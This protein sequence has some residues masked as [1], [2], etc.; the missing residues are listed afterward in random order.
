MLNSTSKTHKKQSTPAKEPRTSDR[1]KNST[2]QQLGAISLEAYAEANCLDPR[3]LQNLGIT[4]K[5][6]SG[7]PALRIPYYNQNKTETATRYQFGLDGASRFSW[8]KESRI[9]PYGLWKLPELLQCCTVDGGESP[10]LFLVEGESNA[11]TMWSHGIPALGIPGINMWKPEWTQYL[12]GLKVYIWREPGVRG[13]QFVARIGHDLPDAFI[14]MPPVGREDINECHML[15]DDVPELSVRLRSEAVP[16]KSIADDTAKADAHEAYRSAEELLRSNILSEFEVLVHELG[17]VGEIENAKLLYLSVTSRLLEKPV[18]IIVKGPSS[19]GK[20]FTVE[21]VL[22]TLPQDAFYAISAMSERALA[23]SQ[24]PL[25]HRMLVIYEAA[26]IN[27]EFASYLVRSLLSEGCI[28]YITVESTEEGLVPREIVREGPTGLIITTTK[29]K[30]HPEN[31][32]RL[33]SLLVKDDP[34]QTHKILLM[35]GQ[36]ANGHESAEPG[37]E[38]WHALQTWLTLG[39]KRDVVIPFANVLAENT[40]TNSVRMRRDFGKVLSLIK[41]CAVLYQLQRE[42]DEQGRIVASIDDYVI[43]YELVHNLVSETVQSSVSKEIRETVNA[44]DDLVRSHPKQGYA[45]MTQLANRLRLDKSSVSRRANTAIELGFLNNLEDH[46]GKS[47]R[48]ILGEKMPSVDTEA[49]PHPDLI[50]KIMGGGPLPNGATVQHSATQEPDAND[51]KNI[52]PTSVSLEQIAYGAPCPDTSRP[53][54][55]CGD[56][57]WRERTQS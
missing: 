11:Q 6:N 22:K 48:L 5:K 10:Y 45:T 57:A 55:G 40:S 56:M 26:G 52:A 35:Q 50:R 33:F 53:C 32:T 27:S 41:T 30:I 21:T 7:Q 18:S 39:G 42:Q 46:K 44:V 15:G 37:M 24:E 16:F 23:Y 31:E 3:F 25:K 19:G 47:A 12:G 13:Q 1:E 34:Q 38:R 2:D 29:I 20:S 14:V 54:L 4:T 36:Q 28:R 43:V 51:E 17:L 49:L 9:I 8:T